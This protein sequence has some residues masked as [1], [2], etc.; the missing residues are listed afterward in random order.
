MVQ[1]TVEQAVSE[2]GWLLEE[3]SRGEEFVIMRGDAPLAW[4]S[5]AKP[6]RQPGSAIGI[7]TY[8]AEDFDA[9][10]EDFKITRA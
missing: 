2:F 8:V 3:V 6:L 10:L 1:V 4:L 5:P 7:I 9:P